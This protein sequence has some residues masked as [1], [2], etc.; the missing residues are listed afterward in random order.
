MKFELKKPDAGTLLSVGSLVIGAIGAVVS[1]KKE[2]YDKAD[3][4][5]KAAEKAYKKVMEQMSSK[6]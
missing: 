4:I 1:S 6:N 5:D 2:K 3:A